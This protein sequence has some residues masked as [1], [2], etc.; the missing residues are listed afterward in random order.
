MELS[1]S[2]VKRVKRNVLHSQDKPVRNSRAK[3]NHAIDKGSRSRRGK[4]RRGS[5]AKRRKKRDTCGGLLIYARCEIKRHEDND[6]ART[7][8]TK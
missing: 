4:I 7:G 8:A 3:I 2:A 1:S 6:K 5:R